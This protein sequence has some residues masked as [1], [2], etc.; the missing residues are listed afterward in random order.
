MKKILLFLTS[1][2]ISCGSSVEKSNLVD[3]KMI[4]KHF[5]TKFENCVI[6]NKLRDPL[7][8]FYQ[9]SKFCKSKDG[10]IDRSAQLLIANTIFRI[11][12]KKS[13]ICYW[14]VIRFD[15]RESLSLTIKEI[16]ENNCIDDYNLQIHR[17]YKLDDYTVLVVNF[18][19]LDV[20][21]FE[22]FLLREFRHPLTIFIINSPS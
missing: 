19:G 13:K 1:V 22:N 21:K 8:F 16:G 20:T 2:L 6:E 5:Q 14:E 17:I 4:A 12:E 11:A 15:K 3:F 9:Y 7:N 18:T 10:L